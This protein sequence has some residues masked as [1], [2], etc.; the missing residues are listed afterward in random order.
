MLTCQAVDL[1]DLTSDNETYWSTTNGTFMIAPSCVT[2]IALIEVEI[3][4]AEIDKN[5]RD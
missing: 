4:R 2:L 1:A 5:E 3:L